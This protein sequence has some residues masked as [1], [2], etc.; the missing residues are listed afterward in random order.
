MHMYIYIYIF[1]YG[2]LFKYRIS[3]GPLASKIWIPLLSGCCFMPRSNLLLLS[4]RIAQF[5]PWKT[6]EYVQNID[7]KGGKGD[8]VV[9]KL[10]LHI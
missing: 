4:R 1:I 9:V 10:V 2:C 5:G 6:S 8:T 3:G 7:S